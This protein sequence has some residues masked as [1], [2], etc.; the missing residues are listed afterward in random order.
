[1]RT[2]TDSQSHQF[3]PVDA[4]LIP[5]VFSVLDQRSL[6]LLAALLLAGYSALKPGQMFA[7]A[8]IG[9][10]IPGVYAVL[11]L[12]LALIEAR[13]GPGTRL[14]ATITGL[15]L[16][17]LG[18]SMLN[19]PAASTPTLL[20]LVLLF[21]LAGMRH[22]PRSLLITLLL[23]LATAGLA[24][25]VR[26]LITDTYP[27]ALLATLAATLLLLSLA[28]V[29]WQQ[30][31]RLRLQVERTIAEDPVTGLGN[32][33]TL[34]AAAQMLWPL[35]HRQQ[36]PVTLMYVVI[37]PGGLKAGQA[38]DLPLINHL[39]RE[40]ANIAQGR[41][42]GSD[43]LVRYAPLEFV[44]M[45]IDCPSSQADPIAQ[46]LMSQFRGW[47]QAAGVAATAHIGATWLPV[48]PLALDD[49]LGSVDQALHRARQHRLGVS[50]AVYADPEHV[51]SG[52]ALS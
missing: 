49:M 24:L 35:A 29:H 12:L 36:L 50:G 14:S 6:R 37:E 27:H 22:P 34:Y 21:G 47:S 43:V 42:R 16:A 44:F 11:Q 7:P 8:W 32:R 28:F 41:L 48:R 4:D 19:D 2:P 13:R 23:S 30:I 17:L 5:T 3:K 9:V 52:I 39:A 25:A 33:W 46:H 40:F 51:R 31:R 1:M 15:D 18:I 26:S 10:L 38:P 20:L 45:L